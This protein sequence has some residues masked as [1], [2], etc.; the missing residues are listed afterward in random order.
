MSPPKLYTTG[1]LSY[2]RGA[3]AV[4]FFWML[5]GEFCLEIME[6]VVPGVLPIQLKRLG[7]RDTVVAFFTSVSQIAY[8]LL[9]PTIAM[10]SD[11]HR[12]PFGRRRPFL[13][14]C[15]P[16][17]VAS[18]VL[19][20]WGD[21]ISTFLYGHS[22][23]L[24][25]LPEN[26]VKLI[27][28]GLFCLLFYI[29]NTYVIYIYWFLYVDVVP[30]AVIGRFAGLYRVCGALGGFAFNRW[31]FVHTEHHTAA[32]YCVAAAIYGLA[33]LLLVWRVK[34][35]SYPPPEPRTG[36]GSILLHDIKLFWKECFTNSF[37]IKLFSISLCFWSSYSPFIIFI[38]FFS[39]RGTAEGY[40]PTLQLP[41]E[42]FGKVRGWTFV[43]QIPIF[44]MIGPLI[45]R[46]HPLR[47]MLVALITLSVSYFAGYL[48]I[49]SEKGLLVW[50]VT[51]QMVFAAALGAYGT[52]FPR[53]CPRD[54]YGAFFAANQVFF[55]LG[56]AVIT[57]GCGRLMELT[58][59]YRDIFIIS[60]AFSLLGF[61]MCLLVFRHWKRLGGDEGFV[62]P[63]YQRKPEGPAPVLPG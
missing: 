19:M 25:A 36:Q 2:T 29:A 35:G 56:L 30:I 48:F 32:I 37:Y 4:M 14:A 16:F 31:L 24:A 5:W 53:L 6:N 40:A 22:R 23:W 50:W 12:G 15:T 42:V 51:N 8:V 20:G 54:I 28:L 62:P 57:T 60:G 21:S 11:R 10:Q 38:L 47:I 3:L 39:T 27:V 61:I 52:L 26:E 1:T 17:A 7:A 13:L 34:E 58:R 49:F 46:L 33:F 43:A 63:R 45:D 55:M 59:N 18:L 9:G 41:Y 44:L